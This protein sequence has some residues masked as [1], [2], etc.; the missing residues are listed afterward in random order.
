MHLKHSSSAEIGC[1]ICDE[2]ACNGDV[3]TDI[4]SGIIMTTN[5][6][7]E[8]EETTDTV[9]D[10]TATSDIQETSNESTPTTVNAIEQSTTSETTTTINSTTKLEEVTTTT[11][12]VPETS[13][14][15]PTTNEEIPNEGTTNYETTNHEE[16]TS[17]TTTSN[18]EKTT[19]SEVHDLQCFD[20]TWNK[21]SCNKI[22]AKETLELMKSAGYN[23]SSSFVQGSSFACISVDQTFG[24]F[25]I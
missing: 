9:E 13:E 1:L 24:R 2:D 23:I 25:L 15:L 16:E 10:S 11:I 6:P 8:S 5:F 19:E 4:D 18:M 21:V 3:S 22:N 12:V 7:L 20:S 14:I 17:E